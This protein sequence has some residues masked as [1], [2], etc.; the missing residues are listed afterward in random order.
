MVIIGTDKNYMYIG[1]SKI[2]DLKLGRHLGCSAF[3]FMHNWH[4]WICF[5]VCVFVFVYCS[6]LSIF[7]FHL[8]ICLCA[9]FIE[10]LYLCICIL[11]DAGEPEHNWYRW[12]CY[13]VCVLVFVYFYSS[14]CICVFAF[15]LMQESWS[16]IGTDR[17]QEGMRVHPM[18]EHPG[19]PLSSFVQKEILKY[20]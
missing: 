16:I 8:Y 3:L 20:F 13:C 17:G 18:F 12:I 1:Y 19:Q 9:Y 5:C 15:L 6:C 11:I 10:Y 14:V 2:S 4:R 7:V